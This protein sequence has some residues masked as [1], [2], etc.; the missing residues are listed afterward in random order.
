MPSA[1]LLPFLKNPG[2]AHAL[3]LGLGTRSVTWRD[4]IRL[5][6]TARDFLRTANSALISDRHE[7][8]TRKNP[9]RRQLPQRHA[10]LYPCW[11]TI[12]YW[13]NIG[14]ISTY[15]V[16]IGQYYNTG[17]MLVR[18]CGANVTVSQYWHDIEKTINCGTILMPMI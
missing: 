13:R 11:Q 8:N 3:Q 4:Q 18:Y 6:T 10:N 9:S 1:L 17:Q 12:L 15:W 7:A 16:H 5:Q 14:P 2:A